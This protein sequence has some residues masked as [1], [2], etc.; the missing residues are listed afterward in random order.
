M[1]CAKKPENSPRN[2]NP[3]IEQLCKERCLAFRKRLKSGKPE[4]R[5]EYKQR[6]ATY[7]KSIK[8]RK[9]N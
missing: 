5:S 3:E 9:E 8:I 4:Y 6:S 1:V 2:W 7:E